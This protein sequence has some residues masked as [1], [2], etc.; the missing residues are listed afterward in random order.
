MGTG[1]SHEL[2][3]ALT[4]NRKTLLVCTFLAS[5]AQAQTQ[6]WSWMINWRPTVIHPTN[7]HAGS[8]FPPDHPTLQI[9]GRVSWNEQRKLRVIWPGTT[10]KGRF[11]GSSLTV[12]MEDSGRTDYQVIIDGDLR[13]SRL[14]DTAAGFHVYPLAQNLSPGEHSFEVFR[15]TESFSGV[16]Q[17]NGFF[18][19]SGQGLLPWNQ[20]SGLRVDFYGD[21]QTVGACNECGAVEQWDDLR[22]H[23]H[24][25]SYAALTSRMLSAESQMIAVSGIGLTLGFQ[26][27]TMPEIWSREA[28]DPS[29]ALYEKDGRE[30]QLIFVNLGQ[31]DWAKGVRDSF[32]PAYEKFLSGL[33]RRHPQAWIVCL[34][35]AM[36]S[37]HSERSPFPRYMTEAVQK[38]RDP[39][40]LTYIFKTRTWEHPRVPEHLAM[41][42]ELVKFVQEKIPLNQ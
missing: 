10:I 35:G 2:K 9:S 38:Q 32:A 36:D 34:L 11:T 18:V 21:S 37:A 16:T 27:Y 12:Q 7:D 15:R 13:N 8:W 40:M 39:K 24:L 42:Q 26:P 20:P 33:R 17:I 4:M 1:P 5:A 30:P 41:A 3:E 25:L 19:E 31:N 29:A 6:D 14:L 23:N 28:P 22:P